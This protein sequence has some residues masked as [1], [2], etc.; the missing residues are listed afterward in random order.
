P[1]IYTLSLHDALPIFTGQAHNGWAVERRT[2]WTRER[3]LAGLLAF[4]EATGRAPTTSRN[5]AGL[6]R[7]L[8]AQ[9]RQPRHYPS[10]YAV[11]RHLD[12]KSTRLN[13]SHVAI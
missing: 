11:L 1:S 6:V 8:P 9:R 13:S 10:A 12:R 3:V 4:H 7:G 5:W 2:W